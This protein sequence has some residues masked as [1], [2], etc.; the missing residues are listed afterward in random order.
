MKCDGCFDEV[1]SGL[2]PT[3]VRACLTRA[4]SFKMVDEIDSVDRIDE[5]FNDFGIGPAVTFQVKR[6]NG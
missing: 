3:C 2:D 5:D 6:K 4:L 1:S